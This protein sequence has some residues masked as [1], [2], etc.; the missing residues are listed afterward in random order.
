MLT[1]SVIARSDLERRL[2]EL[3]QELSTGEAQLVVLDK[4]RR[5][6]TDTMLR[7][8]GAI[9][10][11]EELL[12]TPVHNSHSGLGASTDSRSANG[13]QPAAVEALA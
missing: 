6:T 4:R 9:Q 2:Q 1:E 7:I 3:K 8:A 10:M 5:E 11:L 12:Q 13:L